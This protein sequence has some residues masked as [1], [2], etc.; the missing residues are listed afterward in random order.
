ML[1]LISKIFPS[2]SEKDIR[3][4]IPIVEQ[5]NASCA[6][7]EHLSDEE[8]KGKTVEFRQRIKDAI[9][10]VE[11]QITELS[12][13]LKDPDSRALEEREAIY[14]EIEEKQKEIDARTKEVLAETLPEAYAVVK[15]ACRRLVGTS[16]DVTGRKVEWDMVPVDVQLIGAVVLHQGKIAEMATGGGKTLV[17]TMPLYLNALPGRG[18]HLVTVNDYLALRDSE[19]MGKVFEFLGLSVG[20]IQSN[21]DP[22][23]R[24]KQ[25]ACDI[26]YGTNNEF[27]FD[28]L[29]DNMVVSPEDLVHRNYYYAIV[30]EVDSVLIDEARTPLIISGPVRSE[31]HKFAEMKPRVERLVNAQRN[32]VTKIVAEAEQL[33]AE[34]KENEAGVQILRAYRG[35]P[36][37]SRL[38][39]LLSE[40]SNKK[41]MQ[42]TEIEYLREQSH[43]MHE[44]D[45]ELYYS[46]DEKDHSINLSEKGRDLLAGSTNDKDFFILPDVGT[47]IAIIENDSSMSP[48]VKQRRKDELNLQ[49][50]E[51]S[52]RIHTVTQLL[53][54]EERR[55]GK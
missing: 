1:K 22:A 40:P 4:I 29:R 6:E 38:I 16:W 15:E 35:L 41:L 21:M 12:E 39:K 30:D 28:Y 55:V 23:Q 27:G 52:D 50:A 2:K 42:Q 37:H 36:K 45:D 11:E 5:I 33:L 13:Q 9:Q 19:W 8:L 14:L 24:R 20:C 26:T 10:E 48:E 53:R 7:F 51:R 49:Y 25:Y 34:G 17:A 43:R 31:D 3:R 54:S 47:E 46:I 18:V 32:F 44:I